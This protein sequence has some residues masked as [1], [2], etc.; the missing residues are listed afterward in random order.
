MRQLLTLALILVF[1]GT[2]LAVEPGAIKPI[3]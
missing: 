2:A 3:P 1:A